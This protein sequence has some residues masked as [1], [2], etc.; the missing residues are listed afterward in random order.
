[1]RARACAV[2]LACFGVA[3][4]LGVVAL[5]AASSVPSFAGPRHYAT[6]QSPVSVVIGD[7]NGDGARD[8]ATANNYGRSVSVL[9][10]RG[11][12]SLGARRNYATAA[13]PWSLAI[14]D[15]NGDGKADLATANTLAGTV[16]VF[17]NRGDGSLQARHDYRAGGRPRSIAIGDLNG[18]HK[19]DLATAND[20]RLPTHRHR[21]TVSVFLNRGDGSLAARHDYRTGRFP[22]S[23]ALGD[24]NGD[25][26]PDLVSAS[27]YTST[28][29][30]LLNRGDGSLRARRAYPVGQ[31]PQSVAIGDLNGDGKPDLATASNSVLLNRGDGR[32]RSMDRDSNGP[33]DR[34]PAESLREARSMS[35]VQSV[36]IVDLNG[37]GM[38]DL[39]VST[40]Y[41]ASVFVNKGD[42][43]FQAGV[44]HPARPQTGD[45][46]SVRS[47]DLN[48]DGRRDLVTA[49]EVSD[50][51]SVLINR[52]GLCAVQQVVEEL[53]AE[54]KREITRAGCRIGTI[55]RVYAAYPVKGRVISEKP[56]F[57]AVLRIGSKVNLVVSRGRKG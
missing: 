10:N 22:V 23:L 41:G 19:P 12:G 27:W 36:A 26:R 7:L 34:T 11:D 48:G 14:G 6:G 20:K 8:V 47:G 44:V 5:S 2:L 42:G 52:P 17:L 32:F 33:P 9:L 29:S 39:L 16:S 55:S 50:N 38:R 45:T 21:G 25:R 49:N 56:T 1:M 35:A 51:I 53:L 24:L 13:D 18:D 31:N 43:G 15:V 28:V 40:D 54:A 57:G 4:A 46:L 37:D 30:V 3:L